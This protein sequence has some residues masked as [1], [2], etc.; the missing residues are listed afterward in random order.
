M[1]MYR[2]VLTVLPT[3]YGKSL[4]F[5][6]YVMARDKLNKRKQRQQPTSRWYV[7]NY[8]KVEEARIFDSLEIGPWA[9][10]ELSTLLSNFTLAVKFNW[11]ISF[12]R[13]GGGSEKITEIKAGSLSRTP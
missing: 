7:I 9:V 13:F 11:I 5:Q 4:I 10:N 1:L 8:C 2:D 3:G 6:A 12:L